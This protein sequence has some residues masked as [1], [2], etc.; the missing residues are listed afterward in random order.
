ML[1]YDLAGNPAGVEHVMQEL[2][3]VVEALEPYDTLHPE[4]LDL[5]ER[6]THR[7]PTRSHPNAR[8]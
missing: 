1:A 8:S 5:Y 3:E 2:C 7:K 6:L 4:T